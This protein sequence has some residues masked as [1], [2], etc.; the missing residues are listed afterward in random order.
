MN[1]WFESNAIPQVEVKV[2]NDRFENLIRELGV[3]YACEWFGHDHD[4]HFAKEVV[5][6][7]C[8]DAEI[9]NPFALKNG[10]YIEIFE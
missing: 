4:G 9:N 8:V 3:G 6:S 1:K 2:P 5:N 10:E 7:L